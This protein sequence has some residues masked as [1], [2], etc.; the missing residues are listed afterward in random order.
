MQDL[1][2]TTGADPGKGHR[3]LETPSSTILRNPKN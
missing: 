1:Y 2:I 3:G